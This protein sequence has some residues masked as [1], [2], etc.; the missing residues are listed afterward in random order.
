MSIVT[1]AQLQVIIHY[2]MMN[3]DLWQMFR[4]SSVWTEIIIIIDQC[5]DLFNNFV[6]IQLIAFLC[7]WTLSDPIHFS[8]HYS[9]TMVNMDDHQKA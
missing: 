9:W 1:S 7:A 4:M 5:L 8:Q 3:G 2:F 6:L